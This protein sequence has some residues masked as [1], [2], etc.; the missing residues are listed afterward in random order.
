MAKTGFYLRGAK[1][2]LAGATIYKAK[3]GTVMREIVKP[4]NTKTTAQMRQRA[5]F[6][7]CVKF[8]KHAQQRLFKF[9][10]ED[11]KK[12]ES[13]YNAF[14]RHNVKRSTIYAKPQSDN[15]MFP[16]LSPFELTYGSLNPLAAHFNVDGDTVIADS[17]QGEATTQGDVFKLLI[18]NLDYQAGDFLT[19]VGIES[20]ISS[21]DDEPEVAPRWVIKQ[22]RLDPSDSTPLTSSNFKFEDGD[23]LY[24]GVTDN[25]SNACA[26]CAIVSRNIAGNGVKVSSS[27]LSLNEL[28]NDIYVTSKNEDYIAQA[29]NSW[30][31]TG[32]AILQGSL[33]EP[34]S[35]VAPEF[36]GFRGAG[37]NVVDAFT[38][39]LTSVND[40]L[41]TPASIG[42]LTYVCIEGTNLENLDISKFSASDDVDEGN[43]S[44]EL[45]RDAQYG[46]YLVIDVDAS[47]GEVNI[48]IYYDGEMIFRINFDE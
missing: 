40:A 1:G 30:G 13:D 47:E 37:I 9:A 15:P 16:A 42:E 43:I 7:T 35:T 46:Y 33:F 32:E 24:D 14:V 31:A 22:Y 45:K 11:K 34:V 25:P 20:S 44:F 27:V 38:N 6:A 19:I 2:K 5:L 4:T 21:I 26:V 48:D 18:D 41:S 23:I 3:A 28:A 10:F 8:Y 36:L 12:A 17:L 29:L 39:P